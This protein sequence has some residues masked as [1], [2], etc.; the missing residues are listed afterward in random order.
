MCA[1]GSAKL[2]G[3]LRDFKE[4]KLTPPR[5]SE[6]LMPLLSNYGTQVGVALGRLADE[7]R[8][9]EMSVQL[10][11]VNL[12]TKPSDSTKLDYK[13]FLTRLEQFIIYTRG[14]EAGSREALARMDD[15]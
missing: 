9:L 5:F 1:Q 13:A 2:D 7:K 8:S 4:S 10:A 15:A 6:A 3:L 14:V 11:V 12:M